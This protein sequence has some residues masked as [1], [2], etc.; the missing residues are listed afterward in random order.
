MP[1]TVRDDKLVVRLG[2][3]PSIVE[4]IKKIPG[5]AYDPASKCWTVPVQMLPRLR[6]ELPMVAYDA[7]CDMAFKEAQARVLA[8]SALQTDERIVLPGGELRP[9]QVA[10]VQYAEE[11]GGRVM[12]ADQAGLGK[13]I[14]T[15]AYLYRQDAL[16]EIV[17]VCPASVKKQWQREFAKWAEWDARILEGRK[18]DAEAARH[19]IVIVNYDILPYWEPVL[20]PATLVLDESVAVK[21]RKSQRSKAAARLAERAEHVI[22]LTGTPVLN[23]PAELWNQLAIV[24]PDL[25]L[26]SWSAFG[27]RYNGYHKTRFGWEMGAPAHLEELEGRLRS[28]LLV[29]RRKADVLT[30]VPDLERV[31]VPLE[32]DTEA[33]A[34]AFAGMEGLGIEEITQLRRLAGLAKVGPALRW[35]IEARERL[36]PLVV[37]AHHHDVLDALGRGL[38]APVIDGRMAQTER[39]RYIDRFQ[40]G[41]EPVLVCGTR[42]MGV[43]VNLQAGTNCAFVEMDWTHAAH[44]QAESRL[45]RMGQKNAVTAYY[46][47]A[48]GTIDDALM[49]MLQA[50]QEVMEK[51]VGEAPTPRVLERLREMLENKEVTE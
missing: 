23:R 5:R 17:I 36:E 48:E 32:V 28:T 2:Y 1:V 51:I 14:Q 25:P 11:R 18:A 3:N 47:L 49:E 24:R 4:R 27:K 44:E 39:Q 8:S 21:E 37:F 9:Y 40:A 22:A 35:L 13:T 34:E 46:L 38:K 6:E 33:Y 30:E 26:G 7:A 15:I 50:K 19:P 42:A 29:Q 20:R 41:A 45:H 10:G 16:G 43:G 12:I 31:P